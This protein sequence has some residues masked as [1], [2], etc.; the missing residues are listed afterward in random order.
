MV[1]PKERDTDKKRDEALKRAL[2]MPPRPNVAKIE[3]NRKKPLRPAT[4]P[5]SNRS[6]K[7]SG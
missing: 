4:G 3:D 6:H 2:Q 5:E 7:K 1:S